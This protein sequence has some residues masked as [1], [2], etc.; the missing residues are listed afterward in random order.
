MYLPE[1]FQK[2]MKAI[3]G[4]EYDDFLAGFEK[5]RHYGLMH[6]PD[7]RIIMQDFI[8]FRSRVR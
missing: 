6:R 7:T 8:I 2:K 1:A 3:L 4:E 5:P